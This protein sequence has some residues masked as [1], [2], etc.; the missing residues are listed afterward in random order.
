MKRMFNLCLVATL[1]SF[2]AACSKKTNSKSPEFVLKQNALVTKQK[3][4]KDAQELKVKHDNAIELSDALVVMEN[5]EDSNV[6]FYQLLLTADINGAKVEQVSTA[7]TDAGNDH[8]KNEEMNQISNKTH[9]KSKDLC[10]KLLKRLSKKADSD[11]IR[12]DRTSMQRD[13]DSVV[14]CRSINVESDY[15]EVSKV[16]SLCEKVAQEPVV[17]AKQAVA[18]ET[19][20]SSEEAKSAVDEKTKTTEESNIKDEQAEKALTPAPQNAEELRTRAEEI[21]LRADGY[22]EESKKAAIK[23]AEDLEKEASALEEQAKN[24][25]LK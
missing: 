5:E 1:L 15:I 20:K 23:S 6:A 24:L 22:S 12:I 17:E 10:A 7:N 2:G 14:A 19:V 3:E 11:L 8:D 16:K 4:A 18:A 9:A 25:D 21:R 13:V